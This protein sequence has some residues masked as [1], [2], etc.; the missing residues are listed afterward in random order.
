[1]GAA[2]A[3]LPVLLGSKSSRNNGLD[4]P[5]APALLGYTLEEFM[6]QPLTGPMAEPI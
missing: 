4:A 3:Q 6:G 2:L 5:A 1:V